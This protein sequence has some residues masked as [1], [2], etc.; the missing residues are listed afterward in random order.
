MYP[1]LAQAAVSSAFANAFAGEESKPAEFL[2]RP[3]SEIQAMRAAEK[4]KRKPLTPEQT[5]G[6]MGRIQRG[7]PCESTSASKA[8]A[9]SSSTRRRA[10][11]SRGSLA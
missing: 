2:L 7:E 6:L 8:D 10:A 4:A 5:V 3:E 9:P 11:K 1:N